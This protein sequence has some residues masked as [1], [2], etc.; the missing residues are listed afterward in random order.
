M[1][2][3]RLLFYNCNGRCKSRRTAQRVTREASVRLGKEIIM[4]KGQRERRGRSKSVRGYKKEKEDAAVG[5][6]SA[7]KSGAEVRSTLT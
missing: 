6:E 5:E 7:L 2:T 1:T 3:R 4:R